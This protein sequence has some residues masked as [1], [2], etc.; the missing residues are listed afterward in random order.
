MIYIYVMKEKKNSTVEY[1]FNFILMF[2]FGFENLFQKYI[3]EKLFWE[4]I[5]IKCFPLLQLLLD[6]LLSLP[7]QLYALSYLKKY[8]SQTNNL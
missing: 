4:Y 3:F 8:R 7:M 5:F 2:L 6:P 1:I